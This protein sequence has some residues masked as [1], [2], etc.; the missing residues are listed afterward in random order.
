M[1]ALTP[2]GPRLQTTLTE[3]QST[4]DRKHTCILTAHLCHHAPLSLFFIAFLY[5]FGL[6]PAPEYNPRTSRLCSIPC[7]A[8]RAY[9]SAWNTQH[10]VNICSV[11]SHCS[12]P[13][14]LTLPCTEK[15]QHSQVCIQKSGLHR[16]EIIHAF[17]EEI[18]KEH[19]FSV[20]FKWDSACADLMHVGSPEGFRSISIMGSNQFVKLDC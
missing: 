18:T 9:N 13:T 15:T 7:A 2:S 6:S 14:A 20:H 11:N 12:N 17:I 4:R 8:P 3:G 16:R 1:T 5:C 10:A 19:V